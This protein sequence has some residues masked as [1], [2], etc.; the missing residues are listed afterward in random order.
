MQLKHNRP[1]NIIV[2]IGDVTHE[3]IVFTHGDMDK[4]FSAIRE[5]TG[6]SRD[7]VI[8]NDLYISVHRLETGTYSGGMQ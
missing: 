8:P 3:T 7:H 5:A 2:T 1:V 4:L 6:L